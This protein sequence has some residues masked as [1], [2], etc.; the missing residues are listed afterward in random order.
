[1]T[2]IEVDGEY[3]EPY[4]VDSIQITA[5]QRYSF[6]LNADRPVGNYWIRAMPNPGQKMTINATT[7]AILRYTDAPNADP[8]TVSVTN[9]YLNETLLHS[10][11]PPARLLE[12]DPDVTLFVTLSKND[13]NFNFLING[14]QYISPS[15]PVLLQIMSGVPI[16]QIEPR[17]SV[18]SLPRNKVVEIIFHVNSTPGRPVSSVFFTRKNHVLIIFRY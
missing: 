18:Y 11:S 3:V 1:M 12:P 10:L 17:G 13:S 15:V 8:Q 16:Q 5:A 6:I 9:E 14:T 4:V 2:I 7:T